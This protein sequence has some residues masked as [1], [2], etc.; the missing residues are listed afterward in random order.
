KLELVDVIKKAIHAPARRKGDHPAKRVFHALRIAVN[1]KLEAFNEALQKAARIVAID[2]IIA[3]ITFHSLKYRICKQSFKKWSTAKEVTKN[4]PIL[5][6]SQQVPFRLITRK[7]IV[8]TALEVKQ[9]HRAR[10]AKLRIV[11]K[12]NQWNDEYIYGEG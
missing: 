2:G 12:I 1:E 5:P 10:S 6:E 9:N 8:P 11:Q 7:P 4:Y 3:V